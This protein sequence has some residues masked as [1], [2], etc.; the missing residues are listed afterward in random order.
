TDEAFQPRTKLLAEQAPT[1][2][3]LVTPVPRQPFV[4]VRS[5]DLPECDPAATHVRPRHR[6]GRWLPVPPHRDQL[7]ALA[8]LGDVERTLHPHQRLHPHPERLLEAQRHVAGQVRLTID[9]VRERDP[10][11]AEHLRRRGAPWT[12][13]TTGSPAPRIPGRRSIAW[14]RTPSAAS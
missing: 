8:R 5:V 4:H 2:P 11:D 10:G 1:E 13:S 12:T 6:S 9:Q 7:L 14:S 3:R